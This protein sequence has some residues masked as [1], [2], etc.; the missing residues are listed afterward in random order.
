MESLDLLQR[1]FHFLNESLY[2]AVSSLSTGG[3]WSLSPTKDW[4][5]AMTGAFAAI[6]VP[7]MGI[8]MASLAGLFSTPSGKY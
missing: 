7:L 8:A 3:H 1:S 4:I 5:Y 6:G 2:F